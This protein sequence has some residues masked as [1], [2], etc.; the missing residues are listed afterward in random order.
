MEKIGDTCFLYYATI[1]EDGNPAVGL[2]A[3]KDLHHWDDLGPCFVRAQG[4]V[5]ESPLV[6]R[7]GDRYYLWIFPF[8]EIHVSEE[9]TDF[10]GSES[11]PVRAVGLNRIVAPE[12]I[13]RRYEDRD[14]IGFYGHKGRRIS[15]G[16]MSW[17]KDGIAVSVIDEKEQLKPWNFS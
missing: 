13:D 6:I 3:S 7:R 11:L 15:I 5:P 1:C 12:I 2:S 8:E 9:P 14:L 17:E 16:A 4:W 10:H